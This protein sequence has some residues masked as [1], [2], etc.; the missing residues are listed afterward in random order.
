[1]KTEDGV[2]F[3]VHV[4]LTKFQNKEIKIWEAQRLIDKLILEVDLSK[5]ERKKLEFI[6]NQEKYRL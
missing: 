2:S 5:K 6:A 1:M 3:N 4:I